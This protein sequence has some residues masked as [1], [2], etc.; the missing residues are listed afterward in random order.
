MNKDGNLSGAILTHVDD[1]NIAGTPEFIKEVI[2]HVERELTVSK[3]EENTFR[4]TGLDVK[5]VDDGIEVSMEDYTKSL[6]DI[7]QVRKVEN[8][9]EALT[10]MEMK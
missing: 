1:F 6:Q 9:E 5:V 10:K 4:F 8:R 2:N 3:V 7:K